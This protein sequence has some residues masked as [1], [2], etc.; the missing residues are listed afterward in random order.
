MTSPF[1]S[2]PATPPLG[3]AS[4]D[5]IA[6]VA[7]APGVAGVGV[8]RVSGPLASSIAQT[9]LGRAPLPR[10]AHFSAFHDADR[11]LID[12]GLMLRRAP[13]LEAPG[14]PM[15]ELVMGHGRWRASCEVRCLLSRRTF[16][17]RA[18]LNGKMD[19]APGGLLGGD[20]TAVAPPL[21]ARAAMQSMGRSHVLAGSIPAPGAR[22]RH[23]SSTSSAIEPWSKSEIDLASAP[24]LELKAGGIAVIQP[25]IGE[26]F[27]WRVH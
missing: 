5:T 15:L 7:S 25:K 10:H 21:A 20:L 2:D 16:T 14:K 9:L 18:F 17:E 8:V 3:G 26:E 27:V 4:G 19:L 13:A 11:T 12:H 6:A 23:A 24:T 22:S 1:S